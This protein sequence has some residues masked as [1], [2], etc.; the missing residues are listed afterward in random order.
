MRADPIAERIDVGGA[1]QGDQIVIVGIP[2]HSGDLVGIADEFGT[3]PHGPHVS[4]GLLHRDPGAEP[5]PCQHGLELVKKPWGGNQ[6]DL[7]SIDRREKGARA[8]TRSEHCR[9]EHIGV[10]DNPHCPPAR[11][12]AGVLGA[13]GETLFCP[14]RVSLLSRER[15][16]LFSGQVTALPD[17]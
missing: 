15:H 13:V 2:A 9:Y 12:A 17:R 10:G 1:G 6:D 16:R 8:A 4:F 5:I 14:G 7:V 11:L 3:S